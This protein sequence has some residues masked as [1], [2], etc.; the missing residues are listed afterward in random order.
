[1][2]IGPIAFICLGICCMMVFATFVKHSKNKDEGL[3]CGFWFAVALGIIGSII[4]FFA[5][6]DW[7]DDSE[8]DDIK[9]RMKAYKKSFEEVPLKE[10]EI[11][12]WK[13][14]VEEGVT[15]YFI[16]GI[17]QVGCVKEKE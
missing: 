3:V 15:C 17:G 14:Q 16:K 12:R 9:R 13:F 4:I 1:M 8:F 11:K 10:G 6:N 2:T 7:H 5:T